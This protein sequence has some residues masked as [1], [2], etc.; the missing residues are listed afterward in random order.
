MATGSAPRR[1]AP[2]KKFDPPP[3]PENAVDWSM[4]GV[5]RSPARSDRAIVAEI[6][7]FNRCGCPGASARRCDVTLPPRSRRAQ[8][9]ARADGCK[10]ALESADDEAPL[11]DRI[12]PN[13]SNGIVFPARKLILDQ[14][15]R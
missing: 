1:P 2:S 11:P 5:D 7:S 6:G 8:A 12:V 13:R 10:A 4:T 15:F 14:T 3:G 9:N